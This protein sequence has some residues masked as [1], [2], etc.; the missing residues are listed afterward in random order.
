MKKK[1][2]DESVSSAEFFLTHNRKKP[3]IVLSQ[4][5]YNEL[6]TLKG[7]WLWIF[8]SQK[9]KPEVF[10]LASLFH[11]VALS[12]EQI[13]LR[14]A[15]IEMD[16]MPILFCF[17]QDKEEHLD[18]FFVTGDYVPIEKNDRILLGNLFETIKSWKEP[19]PSYN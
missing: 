13:D 15:E 16:E 3:D 10:H 7:N 19:R 12:N 11:S 17:E 4:K 14:I 5:L 8:C 1:F 18:P 2:L 6:S 9:D